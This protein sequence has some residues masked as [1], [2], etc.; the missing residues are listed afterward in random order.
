MLCDSIQKPEYFVT[1][2]GSG[3]LPKKGPKAGKLRETE[4][5][6]DSEGSPLF[7]EAPSAA[8][9]DSSYVYPMKYRGRSYILNN[10]SI[11]QTLLDLWSVVLKKR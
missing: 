10:Y 3:K 7:F 5:L 1:I 4:K 6:H 11:L 9:E 8:V 2:T